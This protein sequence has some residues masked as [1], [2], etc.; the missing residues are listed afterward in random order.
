MT[1][2]S[3][4]PPA[5]GAGSSPERQHA[6]RAAAAHRRRVIR[7]YLLAIAAGLLLDGVILLVAA[8]LGGTPAALGALVGTGLALIL[9]VP[10]LIPA[11]FALGAGPATF[12]AVSMG[13]WL[14]KM[15]VLIAAVALV[16]HVDG[17]TLPWVGVALLVGGLAS[18]LTEAFVLLRE[19]GAAATL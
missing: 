1:S 18:L 12:G 16:R 4:P 7:A 9:S 10:S 11:V 2:V 13:T 5:D 14:A 17:I 6:L 15:I 3:S 19:R 8:L